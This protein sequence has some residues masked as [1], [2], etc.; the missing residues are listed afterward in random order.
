MKQLSTTS[1]N[2][3]KRGKSRQRPCIETRPVKKLRGNAT[4]CLGKA[5][6]PGLCLFHGFSKAPC[7]TMRYHRQF[8]EN[9][10]SGRLQTLRPFTQAKHSMLVSDRAQV[11]CVYTWPS[12]NARELR[13]ALIWARAERPSYSTVICRLEVWQADDAF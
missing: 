5:S 6:F 13:S 4:V 12:R 10:F 2:S 11:Y 8:L 7:Y 1:L 3:F 9:S